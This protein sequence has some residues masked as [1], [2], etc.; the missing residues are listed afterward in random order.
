MTAPDSP[1]PKAILRLGIGADEDFVVPRTNGDQK[2]LSAREILS[3]VSSRTQQRF[4]EHRQILS[5]GEFL[6]RV[7]EDPKHRVRSAAQYIRDTFDYF[8]T[9]TVRGVEGPITRF[10]LFDAPFAGGRDKVWGQEEV[11]NEVYKI[12]TGFTEKGRIDKLIMLHGPNGSAKST[13]M[14]VLMGALEYYS[15]QPEGALYKLNWIFSD[16]AERD[17]FGFH[18]TKSPRP[19]GSLAYLDPD[20]I[21]FK[22]TCELRDDPLLIVPR[23]ERTRILEDA[24]LRKGLEPRIPG[25]IGRGELCQKC[26]EIYT[27]LENAYKGDWQ[28]IIQHVQVERLYVSKRYRQSAVVIEPQRNVDAASRPLNLE[29][30][31]QIPPILNQSNVHEATGDLVDANRGVVEYSDFFKRPLE[32]NKYLLTTS[33]KGTISLPNTIAYLD[34][35]LF[36]TSNEKQLTVF[37][38]DPDFSSFKG[39]IELVKCPYLVRW[40]IEEKIYREHIRAI[41]GH[42]HVAPHSAS[43]VALWAV[44]TRLKR[45]RS[46]HYKSELGALVS[47]LRPLQKAYLYDRGEAPE[48]WKDQ[49][50]KELLANLDK[51]AREFRD[52]EEE[53]E[54]ML[55][56]AYE[57]RRGASAREIQTLLNEATLDE[58][59][60]CL[61]PLAIFKAIREMSADRSVYDFLRLEADAGYGDIERL[62]DDV[63]REYR[64]WVQDEVQDSCALIEE[65]EYERVF[66]DYF[67]H[68]KAF[69]SSEKVKHRQTGHFEPANEDLM[70]EVENVIGIKEKP[71]VWRKHLILRIAGWAIDHPGQPIPYHDLFRDI[72]K[73]LKQAYYKKREGSVAQIEEH[74]LRFGTEDWPHV[75]RAE[76]KVVK[77]SLARMKVKYGYCELCAK[78]VLSYV[79]KHREA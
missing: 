53:F 27:S 45:P 40:T 12:L 9:R 4:A 39:R 23:E 36:A 21:T 37:K 51:I 58:G 67:V 25:S 18:K 43:V 6:D 16:N 35:V 29:K 65:K 20:E 17:N 50:R 78:E 70:N 26:Q 71:T 59:F 33:E 41:A 69:D 73:A 13:F 75:P 68:V 2:A 30:S 62:T 48:E 57:G 5:F 79:L 32:V 49:E 3:A 11:Q 15:K 52:E 31:Y 42:K 44:L 61:S 46:K 74:I 14:S 34:V 47:K 8:G 24:Y 60:K 28:K 55:D 63:E 77:R 66:E 7:I 56:A 38:R 54:G 10:N 76:Q 64:R 1:T 19:D 72:F 22:L